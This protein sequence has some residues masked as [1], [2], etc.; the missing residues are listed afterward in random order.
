MQY[1][2]FWHYS[3][4][5]HWH[6]HSAASEPPARRRR[7]RARSP[8]LRPARRAQDRRALHCTPQLDVR[9]LRHSEARSSKRKELSI[10]SRTHARI[11][12]R[13][14]TSRHDTTHRTTHKNKQRKAVK[15]ARRRKTSTGAGAYVYAPLKERQSQSRGRGRDARKSQPVRSL[16][17]R[18][19][20]R[21]GRRE[22]MSNSS[23]S[24]RQHVPSTQPMNVCLY[25]RCPIKRPSTCAS[26]NTEHRTPNTEHRTLRRRKQRKSNAEAESL[27]TRS[28]LPRAISPYLIHSTHL[29]RT[30]P[31]PPRTSQLP[32]SRPPPPRRALNA[33]HAA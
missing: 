14:D 23:P 7:A 25:V 20:Q 15:K 29:P 27:L 12:T 16:A 10:P 8:L 9:R 3:N 19:R 2:C 32:R 13:H 11:P 1:L 4:T 6:W 24:T 30:L 17:D 22:C 28:S 21:R 26:Q 5:Y 31:P 18:R 33:S